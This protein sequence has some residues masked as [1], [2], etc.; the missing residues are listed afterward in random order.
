[1]SGDVHN[2]NLKG[3]RKAAAQ[4]WWSTQA[5]GAV[6]GI[7]R[8]KREG[9]QGQPFT[10]TLITQSGLAQQVISQYGLEEGREEYKAG[11][12]TQTEG[13]HGESEEHGG[14]VGRPRAPAQAS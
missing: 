11:P 1:M 6:F 7:G 3:G 4:T 10:T 9:S 13:C 14:E 5:P 2:E 8:K 12:Q